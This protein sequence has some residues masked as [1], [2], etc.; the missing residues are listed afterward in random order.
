MAA[1]LGA[2]GAGRAPAVLAKPPRS[3]AKTGAANRIEPK[4]G[5]ELVR[6]PGGRFHRG[7]EPT[8]SH[9]F[10]DERPGADVTVGPFF[11]GKT[12][13]TIA[14]Y[15]KCVAAGACTPPAT[16]GSCN[17]KVAGREK[18]PVNCIDWRQANA[19]CAWIGGRL[20]SVD[21]WEYA[22]KGGEGRIYPWGNQPVTAARANFCEARCFQL[23]VDWTWTDRSQDD[24]WASTAPV[25]SY[26][27]GASKHGLL[28]MAGNASQWTSSD[29]P[30]GTK[31]ARGGAWDLYP[32]YLRTSTRIKL[33]PAGWFDNVT[34]RCAQ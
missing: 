32:R 17:W 14:M 6:I 16:G 33:R 30:P 24:G 26:P 19:F 10:D 12:D 20:P 7:C 28:D 23:H 22:A 25:G 15:E 11:L 3:A 8:D 5:I 21:E 31:E 2:W 9:C 13:T 27:A 1:I 29:G 18:H 34:V 4:T